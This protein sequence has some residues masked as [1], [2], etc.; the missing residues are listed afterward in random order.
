MGGGAFLYAVYKKAYK[1]VFPEKTGP[2]GLFTYFHIHS[3]IHTY[4]SKSPF[5]Y[6]RA[7]NAHKP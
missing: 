7:Q 1:K 5:S 4:L 2:E 6:I 3:F